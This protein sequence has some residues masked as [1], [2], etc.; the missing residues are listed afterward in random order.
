MFIC[1]Q[2]ITFMRRLEEIEKKR[3]VKVLTREKENPP[4]KKEKKKED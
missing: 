1:A 2:I 4:E 3:E